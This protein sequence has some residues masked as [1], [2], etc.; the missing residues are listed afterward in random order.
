[1]WANSTKQNLKNKTMGG[2]KKIKSKLYT[3]GKFGKRIRETLYT[4]TECLYEEG[5]RKSNIKEEDLSEDYVK[6]HSRTL[7]YMFGY[8]K[9]SDVKFVYCTTVHENHYRKDDYIYISYDSEITEEKD[10]YGFMNVMGY[11]YCFCGNGIEDIIR[12]H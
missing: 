6:I 11:D 9:L 10:E 8:V 5:R 7:W 1:M 4:D 12:G 3:K 2:Q